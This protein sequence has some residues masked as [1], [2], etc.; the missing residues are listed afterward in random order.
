MAGDNS[1]RKRSCEKNLDHTC[2]ESRKEE[3]VPDEPDLQ[4][5]NNKKPR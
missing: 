3:D 4:D 2:S 1:T 5:N